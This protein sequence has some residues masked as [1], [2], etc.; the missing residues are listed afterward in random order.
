MVEGAQ[1]WRRTV[2]R[3]T[4][5]AIAANGLGALALF[6]LLGLLLPFAPDGPDRQL[7]LNAV[8]GAVYLPLAL[9]VGIRWAHR[10]SVP[11]ERWLAA[12]RAPTDEERRLVLTQPFRF[13]A[14]SAV[15]WSIAAVLFTLLNV[16]SSG[17]AALVIGGAMLLA[18]ETT[19]AVGYLLVERI[20]RPVTVQALAGA[21]PPETCGRLGVTARLGM[22]WSLGTGI[23]LIGILTIAIAGVHDPNED[24]ELLAA[25]IAFLAVLG[26]AVGS[27]A[28][29]VAARSV[30]EPI[31][32]VRRAMGRVEGGDYDARVTVDDS[33]E[34]GLLEAGFNSMAAGLEERERIRDLFGR[35]VGREVAQA[36]LERD[37]DVEL[38]GELR[39]VAV[40]FVDVVDSTGLAIRRPPHEVVALLNSF[41]AL[42]VEVVERHC[43]WVNKFEGDG[44]LC[45]FGAPTAGPDAAGDALRAARE[46]RDRLVGELH[47][48]AAGIGV[49]VGPAVAGNVGAQERFE[50][51]VIGDPVNEAARLCVLAKRRPER[52]LASR[53]VLRRASPDEAGQWEAC[54]SVV[55][56]GRGESTEL[57]VPRRRLSAVS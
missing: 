12:G 48:A 16:P 3:L 49:S 17:W 24:P 57:A 56:R 18:A 14:L 1:L 9:F 32:A 21:V 54:D 34:V 27:L 47:G 38:G 46:L 55:L 52:L 8:V 37:G 43:G 13:V 29:S 41:F 50:Y 20:M 11:V 25:A 23:P 36:A 28:I 22:A 7:A 4:W 2:G 10:R 6:L 26:I 53:A 44:A 19:L 39:E 5:A 45:V 33:S 51:T 30:A 42:V 31:S 35:H 40:V 15:A